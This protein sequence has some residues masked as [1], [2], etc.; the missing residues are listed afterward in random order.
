MFDEV[1]DGTNIHGGDNTTGGTTTGGGE[2]DGTYGVGSD[3]QKSYDS[4]QGFGVN[5]T[6]GGPVS[7][8]T[9]RGR[10]DYMNGGLASIL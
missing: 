8:K 10:T 1:Y 7:N 2:G 6:T 4:G 5:A 9:G 3:G